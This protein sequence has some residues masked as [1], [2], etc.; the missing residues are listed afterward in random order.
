MVSGVQ[1]AFL[2]RPMHRR[3]W[4]GRRVVVINGPFKGYCGL[5]KAEDADSVD[6][7]LDAKL[8]SGRTMQRF[9][10]EH[11]KCFIECVPRC[12]VSALWQ[13]LLTGVPECQRCQHHHHV[14]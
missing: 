5:V 9:L 2:P 12:F 3:V 4:E 14:V 7:E 13:T 6:V 10:I 8:A 1:A 11:V